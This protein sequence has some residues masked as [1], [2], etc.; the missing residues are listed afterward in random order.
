MLAATGN[1]LLLKGEKLLAKLPAEAA[2]TQPSSAETLPKK[3]E[4]SDGV[5]Y[6]DI[7]CRIS[8]GC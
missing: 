3:E 1:C 2:E 4:A 6:L 8:V 5:S 7:S